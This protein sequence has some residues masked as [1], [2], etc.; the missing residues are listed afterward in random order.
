MGGRGRFGGTSIITQLQGQRPQDGAADEGAAR[1]PAGTDADKARLLAMAEHAGNMGHWTWSIDSGA[2]TLAPETLRLLG[3]GTPPADIESFLALFHPDDQAAVQRTLDQVF[4]RPSAFECDTRLANLDAGSGAERTVIISGHPEYD[5][6]RRLVAVHGL[7]A[8]V[9]DAFAA[10]RTLQDRTEMLGLAAAI[11]GLGHW[12]WSK[13]SG[14]VTYCSVEM[15]QLRGE[16]PESFLAR[17]RS[18]DAIAAA[19]TPQHR[20][21]YRSALFRAFADAVPYD[22]TYQLETPQ[23]LRDIREIGRPILEN[24]SAVRFIATAQDITAQQQREAALAVLLKALKQ[25]SDELEV[26]NRQKDKLFSIIAHDL[27]TPFNSVM[28]FADL[29]AAKSR[30][31]SPGK[32]ATYAH[33]VRDSALGVHD[34]L[35][36]LLAWASYQ[37]RDSTLKLAPLALADIAASSL[38]PLVLMAE[39][40]GVIIANGLGDQR[41]LADEALVRIVFR[42]LVCNAIKFSRPGDVVQLKASVIVPDADNPAPMV[43]VTVRDDGIGITAPVAAGLFA[44][45]ET[46]S[47][48]GTRGEKGTGLGLFLCHD[49]ISRHGGAISVESEPGQGAAFHFTLPVAP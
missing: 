29:L 47:S 16:T 48:P 43:R 39:S 15:A 9:T 22:I 19:V 45:G 10:V 3:A 35:D 17:A 28:G 6:T 42:N 31:L 5:G 40:K 2:V 46:V 7:I 4:V 49:I 23:G 8:D 13:D 27:R 18:V 36:N 20:D 24:G 44:F 21:A 12:V 37:M 38:E 25:K 26:L 1:L 41:A 14:K 30:E 11:A 34:L 33:M 32:V